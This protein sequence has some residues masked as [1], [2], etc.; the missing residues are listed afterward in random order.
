MK[1]TPKRNG[2]DN[3]CKGLQQY[4]PL[5]ILVWYFIKIHSR[6]LRIKPFTSARFYIFA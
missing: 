2:T 1:S 6:V 4:I 5:N 3:M